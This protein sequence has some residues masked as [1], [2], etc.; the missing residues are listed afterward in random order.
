MY[1]L[2]SHSQLHEVLGLHSVGIRCYLTTDIAML[3][4]FGGAACAAVHNEVQSKA[5]P[6]LIIHILAFPL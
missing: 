6:C 5:H 4:G 1:Q 2:H 3:V